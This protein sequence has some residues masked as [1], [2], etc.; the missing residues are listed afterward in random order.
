MP[1]KVISTTQ[2][3]T[4]LIMHSKTITLSPIQRIRLANGGKQISLLESNGFGKWEF[5]IELAAADPDWEESRSVLVV[6]FVVRLFNQH[7]TVNG[8]KF[9]ANN[10]SE[11]TKLFLQQQEQIISLSPELKFIPPHCR[12]DQWW[13]ASWRMSDMTNS[14]TS[15][16][17]QQE[18]TLLKPRSLVQTTWINALQDVPET[19]LNVVLQSSTQKDGMVLN[20]TTSLLD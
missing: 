7:K 15:V 2:L 18:K 20:A 9:N 17:V 13:R 16:S 6:Q 12:V 3:L 5:K 10:Q 14:T 8:M 11:V 1:L 19:T 4:E